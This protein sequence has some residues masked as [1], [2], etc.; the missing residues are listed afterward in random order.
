[1]SDELTGGLVGGTVGRL[2]EPAMKGYQ[3]LKALTRRANINK[4][5]LLR[6]EAT[7]L[8]DAGK[9]RDAGKNIIKADKLEVTGR[10]GNN[11]VPGAIGSLLKKVP[12]VGNQA[13]KLYT[14]LIGQYADKVTSLVSGKASTRDRGRLVDSIV[15][16]LKAGYKPSGIVPNPTDLVKQA[17]EI[18][19]EAIANQIKT[20]GKIA[21]KTG[22]AVGALVGSQSSN[23]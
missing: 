22:S 6:D 4:E 12:I 9:I 20:A 19:D 23:E 21:P 8:I 10:S 11:P 18:L 16:D 5:I 7:D 3:G 17:N 14:S 1:M 15:T 13:E 2:V